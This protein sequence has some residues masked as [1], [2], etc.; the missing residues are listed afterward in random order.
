MMKKTVVALLAGLALGN[1]LYAD[2]A[3]GDKK[4]LGLEVGAAEV[5]GDTYSE[6]NKKGNTAE[7]GIRLGAQTDDWRTTFVYDYY[8]SSSDDQKVNKGLAMIDYFFYNS[9]SEVSVRPFIGL[10]VGYA[11]YQS[12]AIDVSGVMYG[13]QAGIVIGIT[14]QIDLDLGYR[15]S[16]TQINEVDHL[17]SV[18]FG[19]NYLF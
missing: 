17:S 7:F 5:Q 16:L 4:F 12:T 19:F 3:P 9:G 10:N 6:L 14:P 18:V 1:T 11:N 15:Y 8:N 2:S 13:G